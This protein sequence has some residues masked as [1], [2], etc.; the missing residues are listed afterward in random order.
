MLETSHFFI[1]LYRANARDRLEAKR[2]GGC[3]ANDFLFIFYSKYSLSHSTTFAV[4]VDSVISCIL[5]STKC[6]SGLAG[7]KLSGK[8]HDVGVGGEKQAE[9]PK[10]ET[11]RKDTEMKLGVRERN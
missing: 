11:D 6:K 7:E 9:K 5:F 4:Y 10:P 3:T 1:R 8:T 2:R